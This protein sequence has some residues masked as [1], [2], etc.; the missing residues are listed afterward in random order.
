MNSS[1]TVFHYPY[2]LAQ[3]DHKAALMFQKVKVIPFSEDSPECQYSKLLT[4]YAA[5]Y[6]LK[7]MKMTEK[8]QDILKRMTTLLSKHLKDLKSCLLQ[9]VNVSFTPP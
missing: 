3:R 9:A 6:V 1:L 8:V 4:T 2:C 7:Q 5:D